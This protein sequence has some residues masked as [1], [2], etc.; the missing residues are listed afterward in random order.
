MLGWASKDAMRRRRLVLILVVLAGCGALLFG[1][2][3]RGASPTSAATE[4]DTAP[5][6]RGDRKAVGAEDEGD[7][8]APS[9]LPW[10]GAPTSISGRVQST[11]GEPI[12]DADV[13]VWLVSPRLPT[14]LAREPR[15]TK[16]ATDGTWIVADIPAVR[17]EIRASAATFVPAVYDPP[18]ERSWIELQRGQPTRGIDLVLAPG[19]VEIHGI[20]KDISGGV[21]EGALLMAHA[22]D[23][24]RAASFAKSDEDGKFSTWV[25]PGTTYVRATA[26]G[27]ADRVKPGTAPGF[28]FEISMTPESV[29]AGRVVR[30]SDGKPV[31]DARVSPGARSFADHVAYTDAD[32]RFRIDRL[33]PGRYKPQAE[34]AAGFGQASQSVLLGLGQAAEDLEIRLHP[35]AAL[36]GRVAVAGDASTPC[37]EGGVSVTGRATQH[38][39]SGETDRDGAVEI[40]A[41]PA[42]TYQVT[43]WCD[44]HLAEAKY[45]DV[46]VAE[47][48]VEDQQWSVKIGLAV[49]G[50]VVD[51]EG[52]PLARAR[53]SVRPIGA[54][55]RAQRTTAWGEETDAS[56]R[57]EAGGLLAGTYEMIATHDDHLPATTPP[58]VV[59]VDGEAPA[60]Q[61]LALEAGGTIRG[62]V[63]DGQGRGVAGVNVSVTGERVWAQDARTTDDGSFVLDPVRPGDLRVV[64]ARPGS[65]PLRAPGTSD[66]DVQG[67]AATVRAGEEATV[68]LVVV[69]QIGKISGTVIDTDGA[70][71]DDAF[72]H[73]RRERDSAAANA[74]RTRANVR[75][76]EWERTSK[77]TEQDGAF[78]LDGLEIGA[79]TLMAM[80]KGGGEGIAEHVE[81][82]ATGVVIRLSEGGRVSGTVAS[83]SGATPTRFEIEVEE[84]SL[85]VRRRES[86]FETAGAWQLGEL[87]AG[88]YSVSATAGEGT[89]TAEIEL[90]D[91][92][93]SSGVALVLAPKVD[94]SGTLVDLETGEPVAGMKV[95]IASRRGTARFGMASSGDME[96]VSDDAGKFV[97]RAAPSGAVRIAVAPLSFGT[98]DLAYGRHSVSAV[99]PDGTTT[100]ALPPIRMVRVRTDHGERAGD[101]GIVIREGEPT[102]DPEEV[103][104]EIAVLRPGSPAAAS[105]L[106]V[107]DVIV[108]VDGHDVTGD[109][110]YLFASLTRVKQGA[111]VTITV[112]DGEPVTLV[113]AKPI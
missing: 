85:G 33:E 24:S 106:K 12:A 95:M 109:N 5:E 112:K 30:A 93:E 8:R 50:V 45:P 71:V 19:G 20:V 61:R 41:L 16:S 63:I 52:T 55:A 111:K 66:D 83:S 27:Y 35:M 110:R 75:Y 56:G 79:H 34:L 48:N 22:D 103:P 64:A 29:L 98:S 23:A 73:A 42:D 3:R 74:T 38:R 76:G 90:A 80:R 89:A 87:P 70:P 18:G 104:L 1:L 77:L 69:D 13:C 82:G 17:V 59:L 91:G 28:T 94:V 81:T 49:R 105:T 67:V 54:G 97:V 78:E 26:E 72:V 21:I 25:A 86:F 100:H 62:R 2:F 108:A 14:A 68:E 40:V 107:G 6:R 31:A 102:Q 36:R 44:D 46:V 7:A 57:F 84:R 32:G 43:V 53:V 96:D 39:A 58:Q 10:V 11:D 15:C 37:D 4:R 113:A 60:E 47:A 88:K 99:I 9:K 65:G 92:G 51:A 101:L